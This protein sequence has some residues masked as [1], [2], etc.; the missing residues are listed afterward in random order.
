MAFLDSFFRNEKA[1]RI[2]VFPGGRRH[3]GHIVRSEAEELKIRYFLKMFYFAHFSIFILGYSL[4]YTWS[5]GLIY[6]LFGRPALHLFGAAVIFVGIYFLVAVL[7][8]LLL[9]RSFKKACVSFV[10]AQDEVSVSGKAQGPSL[11]IGIAVV[12]IAVVLIALGVLA[13]FAA[14]S[15]VPHGNVQKP[16]EC[17]TMNVITK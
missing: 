4:A 12:G 14:T 1:G 16:G 17:P 10:S 11:R 5:M 2:V 15:F 8:Y 3:R 13:L 6:A 7:P 9:L